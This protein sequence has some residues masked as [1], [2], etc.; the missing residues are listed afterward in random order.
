MAAVIPLPSPPPPPE[1]NTTSNILTAFVTTRNVHR[2]CLVHL[3]RALPAADQKRFARRPRPVL[4]LSFYF[5][6]KKI[7][8]DLFAL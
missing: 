3:A 6:E 1:A 8:G 5:R 2:F 4:S 7:N